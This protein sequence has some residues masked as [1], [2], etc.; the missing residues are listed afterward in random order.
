MDAGW[1][2]TSSQGLPLRQDTDLC[3]SYSPTLIESEQSTPH[4]GGWLSPGLQCSRC[5]GP[6][7]NPEH[8]FIHKR[9]HC[10][11]AHFSLQAPEFQPLTPAVLCPR[12]GLSTAS[13]PPCDWGKEGLK[14]GLLTV[15]HMVFQDPLNPIL[16][17][18]DDILSQTSSHFYRK[19][20]NEVVNNAVHYE[21]VR[22]RI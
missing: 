14:G 1:K 6:S 16:H 9:Q 19:T 13:P 22:T 21:P 7:Q 12:N 5:S 20:V 3:V 18:G 11:L 10:G 4:A 2:A 17:S 8:G 15:S